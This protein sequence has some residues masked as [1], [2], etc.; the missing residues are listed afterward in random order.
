MMFRRVSIVLMTWIAATA[1]AVAAAPQ[2]LPKCAAPEISRTLPDPAACARQFGIDSQGSAKE[3]PIQALFKHASKRLAAGHPDEAE[4]TLDCVDAVLGADGDPQ[5]RYELVR[6]RAILDYRRERIPGALSRFECALKISTAREDQAA[7]ARDLVN[8][9]TSL[10]RLGDFRGALRSLFLSLEMH[11]AN[12]LPDGAVLNNIADVYRELED[13]EQSKRHYREAIEAFRKQG[14]R[15]EAAHVLEGF[16]DMEQDRGEETG[17]ETLFLEALMVYR[18]VGNRAYELRVHKGLIRAALARGDLPEAQKWSASAQAIASEHDMSLPSDLRL[19]IARSERMLGR[20][21]AA[22]AQLNAALV[23]VPEGEGTRALLLK[24]LAA[25]QESAGDA[26]A[27]Q[28]LRRAH[29]EAMERARAQNDRQL[30]WMRT[31]FEAAEQDRKIDE[32]ETENR[33]R[34][35]ELRQR[36]LWFWLMFAAALVCALSFWLWWQRR[37]HRD[38]I[39]QEA[40]RIHHEEELA[41]YRREAD[42]LAED[43]NLLQLLLDSREDAVCLLDAE[44][45]VLAENRAATTLL[46]AT[47]ASAASRSLADLLTEADHRALAAA[48]EEMED[49]REQHLTI[50]NRSGNPLRAR[51]S[52]WPGGDG[53]VVLALQASGTRT[54]AEKSNIAAERAFEERAVDGHAE[55]R[56][57]T[58]E[59]SNDDTAIALLHTRAHTGAEEIISSETVPQAREEANGVSSTVAIVASDDAHAGKE[60]IEI[61]MRDE[62]RRILVELMLAAVDAWER[63]TATNRLELAEKSRIWRVNIDDGRLRARAMERYLAVS[64]LPQNPRWRDVLRTAYFVLGQCEGLSETARNELQVKI[65]AVLTYTRRDA[66]V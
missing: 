41:R 39:Q 59:M 30:G 32:L 34:T 9:G 33:L 2:T 20:M 8:V 27:I 53:L 10:R 31:R 11:R 51:L 60:V 66:L 23:S 7:T 28:T 43:R 44:G 26:T 12:S 36:T 46:G 63:N 1:T 52:P 29:E 3:A 47:D 45:S 49:S 22:R 62:F 61:Q 19:Q 35:A 42:A 13:Y 25:L 54:S 16:A 6:Q 38:R 64:K 18:D 48:L 65:D 50:I 57:E 15:T 21:D 58:D 40:R 24:E 5:M 56:R 37:R 14:E 4:R 55:H 17:A